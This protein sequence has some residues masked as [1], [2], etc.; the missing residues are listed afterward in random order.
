MS[1]FLV[2][3]PDSFEQVSEPSESL[4]PGPKPVNACST[5]SITSSP[6][7][8]CCTWQRTTLARL[9]VMCWP[10]CELSN[11]F[12]LTLHGHACSNILEPCRPPRFANVC[13]RAD[14]ECAAMHREEDAAEPHGHITSLAVARSHRKLGLASR[15]MQAARE[16]FSKLNN[17]DL[18]AAPAASCSLGCSLAAGSSLCSPAALTRDP[19]F[20]RRWHGKR[21]WGSICVPARARHQQCC[22]PSVQGDAWIS[23]SLNDLCSCLLCAFHNSAC[24]SLL[25]CWAVAWWAAASV[26]TSGLVLQDKRH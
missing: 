4:Q 9:S 24:T 2:S 20:C 5:T 25:C 3:L 6:G 23:V 13:S 8:S 26:L 17:N 16:G 15:L 12:W 1:S 19:C 22:P 18:L 21:F 10:S 7:L 11:S 14:T